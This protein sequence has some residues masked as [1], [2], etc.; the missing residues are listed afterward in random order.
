MG[1]SESR[2]DC[3]NHISSGQDIPDD[4]SET[5]NDDDDISKYFENTDKITSIE[6]IIVP[7]NGR[8]LA[9]AGQITLR[10]IPIVGQVSKYMGLLTPVEH[11]GLLFKT[12][13]NEYYYSQFGGKRYPDLTEC[14]RDDG[15]EDI[16]LN[17]DYQ[18]KKKFWIKNIKVNKQITLGELSKK[19][20]SL[21]EFYFPDNYSKLKNN[22][23]NYVKRL[24][25]ELGLQK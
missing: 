16:V 15:I 19:I 4:S 10:I 9:L 22:C 5:S 23:Q 1:A 11:H 7:M 8:G 25:K 20:Y 18:D 12:E 17:C 3:C 6:K 2:S 13:K 24:L 14:K 21:R